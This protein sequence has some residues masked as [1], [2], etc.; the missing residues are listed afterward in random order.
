MSTIL[1]CGI[2]KFS[3]HASFFFL[4]APF[5]VSATL[6]SH[7]T[8]IILVHNPCTTLKDQN[9]MPNIEPPVIVGS[10]K[11]RDLIEAQKKHILQ[12]ADQFPTASIQG[13]TGHKADPQLPCRLQLLAQ[14]RN[15]SNSLTADRT[16]LFC[17][18]SLQSCRSTGGLAG[19]KSLQKHMGQA[20]SAVVPCSSMGTR[21]LMLLIFPAPSVCLKKK[22]NL[23]SDF[24]LLVFQDVSLLRKVASVHAKALCRCASFCIPKTCFLPALKLNAVSYRS[25]IH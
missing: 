25:Y 15:K 5:Q 6:I 12:L 24:L 17:L 1:V 13:R 3:L 14:K 7:S 9:D 19:L 8:E 10:S 23:Y 4:K 11:Q 21:Y 16:A 22:K 20:R 18:L 2:N